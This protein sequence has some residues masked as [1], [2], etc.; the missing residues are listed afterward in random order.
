MTCDQWSGKLDAYVDSACS[1]EELA[2]L[3]AHLRTCSSCSAEALARLQ[4]KRMTRAAAARY[5]P[6]PEFRQRVAKSIQPK[7]QPVWTFGW[8]P[9]LGVVAVALVLLVARLTVWTRHSA[10]E[11]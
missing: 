2:N 8:M 5:S 10:R 11:Q 9:R 3:E 1:E 6:S 7:R 4:M